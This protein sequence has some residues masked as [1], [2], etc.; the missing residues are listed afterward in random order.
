MDILGFDWKIFITFVGITINNH[1]N[2][3]MK[4]SLIL[5][6]SLLAMVAC[7]ETNSEPTPTPTPDGGNTEQP[8]DPKKSFEIT[9]EELHASKAIT[10][11]APE[12]S[13]MYYVMYLEE[14]DY[15]QSEGINTQEKLWEDD[16]LA[17]EANAIESNKNLKEYM[18]QSNIIFQGTKRVQWNNLLPGIKSVL[19]VYGVEFNEDG[20]SY[21]SVTDIVWQLLEP[22]SAP[23]QDIN[24]GI[25]V[26]VDGADV[27]ISITPE[28]FEGHY[29]VKI[30]D[31]NSDL[32]PTDDSVF[33]DEYMQQISREWIYTY[34]GNLDS[35]FSKE[36]ILD[37]VCFRGAQTLQFELDSY[38]LYSVLVYAVDEYDGFMQVVSKPSYYN[39]STE[40][41]QQ[42]DMEI[43]IEITNCYVRVA[44][45]RI[46][47]TDPDAQYMMYITP[48]SYLPEDYTNDTLLDFA[49]GEFMYYTYTFKGEITSHLNTLYPS[50]EY[51]VVAFGYSGGVVTTDVYTKVF[52]T[53][54]EGVCELEVTDVILTG[55]YR[56]SDLYKYD[57]ETF[58]YYQP[59][60]YYDSSQYIVTI[61]VKTSE[62]T[63][64]IFSYFIA[65]MDYDWAGY[66]TVFFDLLIDTCDPLT[67]GEGFWDFGAYY[68]CAAAFDYKG[69]VTPMWKSE[70][71]DWTM[72]DIRPIEEFIEKWEANQNMQVMSLSAVR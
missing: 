3:T 59:P 8:N 17:F 58:K 37:A 50:T 13:E 32:Y 25:D 31:V 68:L 28:N 12:D 39:F 64:D 18:L 5:L 61:E 49:L 1:K 23:L 21:E 30:V 42:S 57:P 54:E 33:T 72:D 35:G 67:L 40:E 29:L 27:E 51:V 60:Y 24:F 14:V 70:L 65:K 4:K 19:Y 16:L 41:V 62:P 63:D 45:L 47:A 9:V 38:V 36:D 71:Y 56:P 55:P 66:E 34:D 6:L 20:S 53:Q 69:D 26:K 44:D 7:T 22:E 10:E 2:Y 52:K 48:T 11:V 15:L 46:T 43:D